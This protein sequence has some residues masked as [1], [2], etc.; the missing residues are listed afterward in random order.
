MRGQGNR[1]S[2]LVSLLLTVL[3]SST[4]VSAAERRDAWSTAA[5]SKQDRNIL[6]GRGTELRPLFRSNHGDFTKITVGAFPMQRNTE[7]AEVRMAAGQYAFDPLLPCG[8]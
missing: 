6:N 8:V 3:L 4:G 2:Q 1:A 7:T 5:Q